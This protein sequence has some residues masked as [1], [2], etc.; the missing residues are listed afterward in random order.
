MKTLIVIGLVLSLVACGPNSTR[1]CVDVAK[2][3]S[4]LALQYRDAV[5]KLTDGRTTIVNQAT[6]HPGDDY[7]MQWKR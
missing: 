4:I 3:D 6:L 2:V 7:C 1:Q 5:I